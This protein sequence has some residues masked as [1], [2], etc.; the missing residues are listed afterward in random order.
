MKRVAARF[1]KDERGM[2]FVDYAIISTVI[3]VGGVLVLSGRREWLADD[4]QK[5]VLSLQNWAA[6]LWQ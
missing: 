5:F 2:E 4:I 6:H 3:V 1:L